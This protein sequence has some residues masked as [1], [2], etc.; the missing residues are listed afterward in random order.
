MWRI[1]AASFL[2]SCVLGQH[3]YIFICLLLSSLTGL[4]GAA[5]GANMTL[6]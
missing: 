6:I 4:S 5:M 3:I 1:M 2:Y